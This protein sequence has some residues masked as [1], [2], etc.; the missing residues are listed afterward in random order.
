[1]L[2]NIRKKHEGHLKKE[3]STTV[4]KRIYDAVESLK[5]YQKNEGRASAMLTKLIVGKTNK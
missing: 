3:N 2:L 1:M 4:V 5:N